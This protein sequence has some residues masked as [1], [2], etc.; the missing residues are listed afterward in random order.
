MHDEGSAH[1][2]RPALMLIA[3]L[4]VLALG[5]ATMELRDPLRG[6]TLYTLQISTDPMTEVQVQGGLFAD[7]DL[8]TLGISALVFDDSSVSEY[9]LWLRH[10][11]PRRWFAGAASPPLTIKA[12]DLLIEPTPIHRSQRSVTKGRGLVEKLEFRLSPGDLA[13]I[14]AASSVSVDLQT[15]LLAADDRLVQEHLDEPPIPWIPCRPGPSQER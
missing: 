12:G 8:M 13:E 1:R 3:L 15:V 5:Q 4:P 14:V 6:V 10:D 9:V 11:G 7:N 2:L